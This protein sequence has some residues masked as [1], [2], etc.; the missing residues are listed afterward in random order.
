MISIIVPVYNAAPFLRRCVSSILAQSYEDWELIL[1]DDGS[2]DESGVICDEFASKDS[3]IKVI[4]QTNGGVSVARNRGLDCASGEWITFSDAD[5]WLEEDALENYMKH[6]TGCD[7]VR[8]GYKRVS[9]D[10]VTENV[11]CKSV[12]VTSDKYDIYH[13]MESFHYFGFLWNSC[14]RKSAIGSLR[15]PAG[16]NWCEDHIFSF[17]CCAV[18]SAVRFIPD[19]AYNYYLQPS[20]SLSFPKDLEQVVTA[21]ELELKAKWTLMSD[22][23]KEQETEAVLDYYA[24]MNFVVRTLYNGKYDYSY[25]KHICDCTHK[26][27]AVVPHVKVNPSCCLFYQIEMPFWMKDSILKLK[28]SRK[29]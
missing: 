5:D 27:L 23:Q 14:F 9:V 19:I 12:Y 8:A 20:A 4:H 6:S 2:K 3:R 28:F 11:H 15:F 1:V 25:R 7:I 13:K 24:K 16:I 26:K 21:S 17:A 22:E 18:A 10:G 29:K